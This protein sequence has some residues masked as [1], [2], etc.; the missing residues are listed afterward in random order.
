M[1][2]VALLLGVAA[3]G[4][5]KKS[6]SAATAASSNAPPPAVSSAGTAAK[7]LEAPFIARANA[8]C[9][10]A[11]AAIDAHGKFPYPTFDPLHPD[12]RLL[13]RIGAFFAATQAMADR[14]PRELRDL[15]S[16]RRARRQWAELVAL[17]TQSRTIRDRQVAAAEASNVPAFVA[18]VN[19]VQA[20]QTRLEDVG[21]ISGFTPASPCNAVL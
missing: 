10:R 21:S 8:V 7:T 13:P 12:V 11:K 17:V 5:S 6:G 2:T 3:C 14:V 16:P 9:A 19:A 15:G 1:A 20:N 18:T 4:S